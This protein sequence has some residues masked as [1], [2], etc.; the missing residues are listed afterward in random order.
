[1]KTDTVAKKKHMNKSKTYMTNLIKKTLKKHKNHVITMQGKIKKGERS[2]LLTSFLNA[3][4]LGAMTTSAGK[5]F[6]TGTTM[7]E[8]KIFESIEL[9]NWYR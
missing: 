1:M 2:T 5:A 9:N 3:K 7:D 6:Q 4:I 8:N